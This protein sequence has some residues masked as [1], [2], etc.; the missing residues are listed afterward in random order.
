[1]TCK[2]TEEFPKNPGIK[3][4]SGVADLGFFPSAS[5]FSYISQFHEVQYLKIHM[6]LAKIN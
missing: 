5:N 2:F 4:L 3:S 6:Q 1:L